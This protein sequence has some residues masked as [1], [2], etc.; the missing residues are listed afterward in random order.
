MGGRVGS[1]YFEDSPLVPGT[2]KSGFFSEGG[3]EPD[4][5]L[6]YL[7]QPLAVRELDRRKVD[8]PKKTR[9]LRLYCMICTGYVE[10]VPNHV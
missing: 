8:L 10:V 1:Q 9:H 6:Q 7:R 3:G 2:V 5:D 4:I